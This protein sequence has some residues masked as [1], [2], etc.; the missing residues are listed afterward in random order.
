[1]QQQLTPKTE[2]IYD[3]TL[4]EGVKE[5]ANEGMTGYVVDT[6]KITKQKGILVKED[7]LHTSR[8][9][10]FPKQ[11][12]IGTKKSTANV[13]TTIPSQTTKKGIDDSYN[14]PVKE[15]GQ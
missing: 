15:F 9:E 4:A 2:N 3:S 10:A 12:K 13:S 14:P 7:F 1:M 8:Y 11:I 6:Y 5:V